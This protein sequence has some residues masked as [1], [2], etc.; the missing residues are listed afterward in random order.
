MALAA[1]VLIPLALWFRS[2]RP[3]PVPGPPPQPKLISRYVWDS[4][5]PELR[6]QKEAEGFRPADF[7]APKVQLGVGG[8]GGGS[9][10]TPK[11]GKSAAK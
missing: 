9:R 2:T 4:M 5:K 11:G 1:I 8:A 3:K 10:S 6:R 7:A